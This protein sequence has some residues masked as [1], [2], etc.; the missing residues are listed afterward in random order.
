MVEKEGPQ[1][2]CGQQMRRNGRPGPIEEWG[3]DGDARPNQATHWRVQSAAQR[4]GGGSSSDK[5][6]GSVVEG[7]EGLRGKHLNGAWYLSACVEQHSAVV[8]QPRC[9]VVRCSV[10]QVGSRPWPAYE[11]HTCSGLL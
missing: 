5:T 9:S 7:R 4:R 1:G 2:G 10:G 11:D 8:V 3:S 6:Q